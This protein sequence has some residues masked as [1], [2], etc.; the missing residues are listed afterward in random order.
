MIFED[1]DFPCLDSDDGRSIE[2]T[3]VKQTSISWYDASK[4]SAN[5]SIPL[6]GSIES[7][8]GK[9][10]APMDTPRTAER[11]FGA[12][13]C[14]D[15]IVWTSI[16]FPS[17]VLAALEVLAHTAAVVI[18]TM[19]V[20]FVL[21]RLS[22]L[23]LL[24]V[25]GL[26]SASTE[27][28]KASQAF[29]LGNQKPGS[30]L[31]VS[32]KTGAAAVFVK[33][34]NAESIST[35][36][37]APWFLLPGGMSVAGWGESL[38]LL[39]ATVLRDLDH[40]LFGSYTKV[41][42]AWSS[43]R[44][45]KSARTADAGDEETVNTIETSYLIFQDK[46]M[47]IFDQYF[48][49]GWTLPEKDT[50]LPTI[51]ASFPSVNL[52]L[53]IDQVKYSCMGYL[54]W[55]DCF[56]ADTQAGN[57]GD[58]G[59]NDFAALFTGNT[60]G[61]P[62]MIHD[63]DGRS[64]V[65]SSLSNFFVSGFA[66]DH[67]NATLQVGL[68]S[69]LKSIPSDFHHTSVMVVGT[70]INATLMEWG[71]ILLKMGG[72]KQRAQVYDDFML[73]HLGYWTDNG[74]YHYRGAHEEEYANMEEALLAVK[75]GLT[76]DSGIPIRYVQWDDWWMESKGDIP[77][78]LSWEAKPEVFPSGF[79]D[80]LGMPLAMYAP[81]YSG[82]NVWI[83]DYEWKT[84][85]V[86]RGLTS[87][88]VDPDFYMD[89]FRNGTRIGM[90]MFEQDFLCS[91]GIG[92]SGL[93]STD[94]DSGRTWMHNMDQAAQ[95]FGIKLQF[96]MPDPYHLLESTRVFSVTNARA[97]GDN[98]RNYRGVRSMG[99]NGLFY[100]SLGVFA[101]RDNV[102]T[103]NADVEQTGCG[104]TDFCYQPA[105]NLDNTV[106]VL[107]GGP[108]GIADKLG[109]TNKTL[110]MYACR[111]DGLMLRPRWPLA[112][113]DF[114]FTMDD[115][116]GSLVWAAHDDFGPFRWSYILGVELDKEIPITPTRIVQGSIVGSPQTMVAWEVKVG[117]R[118]SNI[119]VF[120][121]SSPFLLPKSPRLNLPYDIP[122]S[123]H[124][125]YATAP[126]LPNGM[127]ILGEYNKWVTMSFGRVTSF[128]ATKGPVTLRIVGAPSETVEYAWIRH[129]SDN[130]KR[131]GDYA[132]KVSTFKCTFPSACNEI[133]Q[134]FNKLCKLWIVC[135]TSNGCKCSNGYENIQ[136]RGSTD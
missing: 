63:G 41:T 72:G 107:S 22:W 85:K 100:Y 135:Q 54:L 97:T 81:E 5:P 114:S 69:T 8:E 4:V 125:H 15:H 19:K 108:Y 133:D 110:T 80:W 91:Y 90:V 68:R 30:Y 28:A 109:S 55:G 117:E 136:L 47:V 21:Q 83:S 67:T 20:S 126:V 105:P 115:S 76:E 48:P 44:K 11:S 60:H 88:P 17:V 74:A 128:E 13:R 37:D 77:G 58:L 31:D 35:G 73:A 66:V 99:Q 130:D 123:S 27:E 103:T 64:V 78:M 57:W 25:T 61:Q 112:S 132:G 71:D 7:V 116:K 39:A 101:S 134:H 42:F 43:N 96:C 127:V 102:W 9:I 51:V 6:G 49:K 45:E 38:F 111:A 119:T 34:N 40:P 87:I 98:T 24:S 56:A 70:G 122:A 32:L 12:A 82:E 2:D 3:R 89:L 53:P 118:I 113:L 29:S 62:W 16:L 65:W 10:V 59:T 52:T 104:N 1:L 86:P 131:T 92:N 46:E 120:S 129:I 14:G 36:K 75:K 50:H 23:L 93:T 95:K 33:S 94:V 18:L 79:S 124:T 84:V 106:A 121:D 26:P